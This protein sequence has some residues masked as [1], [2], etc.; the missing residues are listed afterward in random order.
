M[1]VALG[2]G[3]HLAALRRTRVGP[4][5][6]EAATPLDEVAPGALVPME[7][8]AASAFPRRDVGES[9]AARLGHGIPLPAS[10]EAGPVAVF[11][12]DGALLALVEDRDGAARPLCV[13]V[14]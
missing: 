5:R 7:D 1:G 12:P 14:G 6:I 11:G 9:D 10:G 13:L 3:A 4:F 2:T 8:A